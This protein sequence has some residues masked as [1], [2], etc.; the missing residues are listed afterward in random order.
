LP[1]FFRLQ[2]LVLRGFRV[3]LVADGCERVS[4]AGEERAG[5]QSEEGFQFRGVHGRSIGDR[6]GETSPCIVHILFLAAT[7]VLSAAQPLLLF[8]DK[9]PVRFAEHLDDPLAKRTLG[10]ARH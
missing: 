5:G 4:S 3:E 9:H 2:R 10:Q 1:K 6:R 7:G 8:A